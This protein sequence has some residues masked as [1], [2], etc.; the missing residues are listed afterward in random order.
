MQYNIT[1]RQ[2]NKGWQYIISYKDEN[3]K[4]RQKSKQGF[5]TKAMAKR[6]ADI[7]LEEMK[8][9][10]ELQQSLNNEYDGISFKNF[11]NIYVAHK[12]L[13]NEYGTIENTKSA[14][15]HFDS[16]NNISMI[17]IK[18]YHIQSCVDEMLKKGLSVST[19]KKNI[20]IIKTL[21]NAA[22]DTFNVIVDNPVKKIKL[23]KQKNKGSEIN[24]NKVKALTANELEDLLNKITFRKYYI[25]SLLASKCGLRIGEIVGLTWDCVNDTKAQIIINKQWKLLK[26][27]KW[28]FGHT[29]SENSN[30]IVPAPAIVLNELSKFKKE[31]PIHISNRILP[32]TS[33]SNFSSSLS[34]HYKKIGYD[35]TIHQ[36]RHTYATLLIANGIDF[37]TVANL[38]GHDVEMTIKTYSH[39]TN[40]MLENA[41]KTINDIF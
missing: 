6:A 35:I 27:G 10:F 39:V 19:I 24:S 9:N 36:L 38:M 23:P 31:Y 40:D 17:D 37:K 26:N 11:T 22:I 15:K 41:A 32:Y 12:K 2:K 25:A 8:K 29:K 16:L 33:T 28:G 4:W 3:G 34:K 20:A 7:K 30:R 1:F 21:F 13:Y 14:L 18:P 5:K